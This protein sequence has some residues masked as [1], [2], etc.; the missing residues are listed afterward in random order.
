MSDEQDLL[1]KRFLELARKSY[2]RDIFTFTDFLGLAEQSAF[3]EIERELAGIPYTAFGGVCGAE[4]VMLRFGSLEQLGYE[5]SFPIAIIKA[6]P[7]NRK[8]ADKLT[9]RDFLGAILNLGIERKCIGDIAILDN[10]GY[11]FVEEDMSDFILRN[12]TRAK[13]T[14]LVLSIVEELPKGELYRTVTKKIQANGERLDAII[15]KVFSLSREDAQALFC[16]G[17][18]FVSGKCTE[19]TSYIPKSG[20]IISVRGIGRLIYRGYD[21]LTKKGKLNITVDVYV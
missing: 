13:H 5:Q 8:F 3:R 6:E 10:V 16:K 12:L 11:I 14:E 1:K 15:A 2:E 7:K 19:N 4:R 21:R 9:H 18:V 20:E 17:L